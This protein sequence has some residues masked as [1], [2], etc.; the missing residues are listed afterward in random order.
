MDYKAA[1]I[2]AFN[3]G[4]KDKC[5][6]LALES[7]EKNFYTVQYLYEEI[8]K[9]LLYSIDD[10]NDDDCIWNEHVKTSIMRTVIECLYPHIIKLKK[11]AIPLKQTVILTCP[12]NE[13][14]E[15]GLRM[16]DDLFNI[17]GYETIFIGTNT[18]KN[19]V[20]NAVLKTN[21]KYL[22][23]SV[24]DYYLLF[25]AQKMI[26]HIKRIKEIKVIVGGR[27]F[28]ENR[29]LIREIGGDIYLET[30]QDFENLMEGDADEIIL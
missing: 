29:N 10:C 22:A 26:Q 6:E 13:Y 2:E 7:I 17:L 25:E 8:I 19:Q 23:V 15:I 27:A 30:F 1:F 11:K 12:E 28:K 5:V 14:H 21:P 3:E 18:P 24:T 20:L 9:K 16:A 4:N